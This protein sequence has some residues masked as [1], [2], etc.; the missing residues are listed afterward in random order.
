VRRAARR[1]DGERFS[2]LRPEGLTLFEKSRF[3]L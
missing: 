2:T 3:L 1:P